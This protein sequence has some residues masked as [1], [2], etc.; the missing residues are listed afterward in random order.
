MTNTSVPDLLTMM[1]ELIALPSISCVDAKLDQSNRAVVEKLA[2]WAEVLGFQCEIMPV[3]SVHPLVKKYNLIATLGTGTGGLVFSGH[4]DTVPYDDTCWQYNPFKLT[5]ANHRL[6]GLGTSDMKAFFALSLEAARQYSA[7]DLQQPL[8][9]LATADEETS[10][11]GAKALV[12]SG[13][14]KARHAVIGEPT[15]MR[16]V[17]MHKG[18]F[19]EGIRIT[20]RSGHSSNPS[21]G[22]NALEGM[23]L[24]ISELLR[25]RAE[26]QGRYHNPAFHVPMPTLNLGHIHGGDNP[27][28]ICGS[29]ELHID[30]RPLPGMQLEELKAIL[31]QRVN[32]VLKDRGL[33]VEFLSLFEGIPAVE[34]NAEAEIVKIAEKLTAHTAEAVA[35]ATEAPYLNELGIETIIM[36]PGDI[37]QAHQPD[38]FLALDRIQPTV[39]ILRRLIQHF[40]VAKAA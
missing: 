27:N 31:Y 35:F 32:A 3:P 17:R 24:V 33:T 2:D 1:H 14:P 40:C 28:R 16:P 13:K 22:N 29:C 37:E 7:Q 8:I 11:N 19:M 12:K 4:T 39:D 36:G 26:W 21:L 10:M 15:G 5:E 38:E 34:T 18:I 9:L 25:W 20:G 6:Y 23:H 30:L